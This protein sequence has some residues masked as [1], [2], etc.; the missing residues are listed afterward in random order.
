MRAIRGVILVL[1]L[2]ATAHA[3]GALVIHGGGHLSR[4]VLRQFAALGGGA[5]G[6]LVVIP[7]A[8]ATPDDHEALVTAMTALGFASVEVL[9][10]TS[11]DTAN[12][13]AFVAP[14]T[15]ATAVWF[16]GGEQSRL[17][18]AYH[19]T[20]VEDE[21]HRLLARGGVIGGSSAG[22][23]IMSRVMIRGGRVTPRMGTGLD[24]VPGAIIDQ[25]FIAR[26]RKARLL[27]ALHRHRDLIGLGIDEGT[28]LIV[29]DDHADVVGESTVTVVLPA[30][31]RQRAKIV[32]LA[33]GETADLAA[34]T[35]EAADRARTRTPRRLAR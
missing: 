17:E 20:A 2:C 3:E 26:S 35:R 15:T 8:S 29:H 1:A 19:G 23:A 7:T 18:R 30:V 34:L 32:A 21:L 16:D 22:A 28:A 33:S 10:T 12:D 13:A 4:D 24:L 11:R 14:L 25:H 9:H 6:R 31:H 5:Q 27:T